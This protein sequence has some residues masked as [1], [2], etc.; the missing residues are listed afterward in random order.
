MDRPTAIESAELPREVV[1]QL[2]AV[3]GWLMLDA[4]A[5][6]MI[7]FEAVPEAHREHP[8]A[9]A[10][11]WRL[12]RALGRPEDAWHAAY[13]LCELMPSCAGAWI[14]QADCLRELRGM[15]AAADLLLSVVDRFP[16]E[17]IIPYNLACCLTQAGESDAAWK[18]LHAAFDADPEDQLKQLAVQDPDLIPLWEKLSNGVTVIEI[19]RA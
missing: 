13:K 6:A 12:S 15:Q 4:P 2:E 16:G 19:R 7:E 1:A 11:Q 5:E 10:L 8:N 18:W 17:P 14:C 9:L 3:E